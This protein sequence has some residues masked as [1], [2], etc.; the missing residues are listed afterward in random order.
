MNRHLGNALKHSNFN[1]NLSYIR[2]TPQQ[3]HKNRQHNIIWFDQPFSKNIRTNIGHD[4]LSLIDK[5]FPLYHKLHKI[6]NRNTVKVSYS[7]MNNIKSFITR[8]N[9]RIIRKSKPQNKATENCNCRNKDTCPLQKQCLT[10]DIVYKASVTTCNTNTTKH[11]MG[12]T[13]KTF[14]EQYRNHIKCFQHKKIF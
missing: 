12:M 5:H 2:Y 3:P 6:F 10:K 9:S 4:F 1:H 11:Y 13:S 8:H 14:K 7:C